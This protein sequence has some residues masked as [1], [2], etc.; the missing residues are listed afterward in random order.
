MKKIGHIR[1]LVIDDSAF[2]RQ[3]I[4]R[5]LSGSPLV[6]V[7]GVARDGEDALRKTL[8]SYSNIA[9]GIPTL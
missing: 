3:V 7:I 4:R 8:Q 5:M 9:D 6:E 2:S 1:V